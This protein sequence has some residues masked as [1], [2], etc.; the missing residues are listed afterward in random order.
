M[1]LQRNNKEIRLLVSL[2]SYMYDCE[3]IFM[4]VMMRIRRFCLL[5]TR[6]VSHMIRI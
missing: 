2:D 1:E 6:Y 3:S 5:C 4:H